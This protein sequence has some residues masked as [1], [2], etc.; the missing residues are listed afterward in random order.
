MALSRQIKQKALELGFDVV[1]MT[2][3]AAVDAADVEFLAD[4]LKSGFAGQM[5]YMYR[6]F[7]KRINPSALLEN[8]GSVICVGLNYKPPGMEDDA[9]KTA[10]PAGTIA[11]YARY[12][13]YH[14]FIKRQLRRL[15]D[16]IGSVAGS[17][18]RYKVCVD[19]APLAERALAAR[20]G[21]GFIGRNHMLINPELGPEL[22]LAEV[23]TNLE[24]ECD[25]PI[26]ADCSKCAKC[27]KACPTGALRSDGRFDASRCI[28]YLTIEHKDRIPADLAAKVGDRLFG[29]DE[30][31]L[32]CPLQKKAPACRN[33]QLRFYPGR[34]KVPLF[35][36]M[37]LTEE[38]FEAR[39]ADSPIKRLGIERLK[40]NAKIALA[41]TSREY[42]GLSFGQDS[43]G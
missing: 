27:I 17:G 35:E 2:D 25:K 30:C 34:A 15:V 12:E 18:F 37:E 21:L 42:E 26:E 16:F 11:R 19:S 43:S 1:G 4:W 8:A 39:F 28:S 24:L 6:N 22:F 29:C 3:A 41:N 23:V 40:R 9:S 20:A 32:A 14:L 13:D 36:V 31:V 10:G 38:R 33:R 7:E 5:A